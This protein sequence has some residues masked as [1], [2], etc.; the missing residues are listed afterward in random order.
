MFWPN[1]KSPQLCYLAW[2][3]WNLVIQNNIHLQAAHIAGKMNIL[4]DQL[5]RTN[6][7][8]TEW[9]LNR[10]IVDTILSLGSSF[11]RS[12]CLDSQSSEA[13]ILFVDASPRSSS[14]RCSNN[15]MGEDVCLCY[16][17]ICLIP[18][19]LQYMRQF[20]CQIILIAPQWTRR[21]CNADLLQFLIAYPIRL[22]Y[23]PKLVNR[24]KTKIYHPNPQ[25]FNLTAWLL[26]TEV[27]KKK[28]FSQQAR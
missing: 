17:P 2:D 13:N 14:S 9:S 24:P 20:H 5:S 11:D 12:I 10:E 15:F 3:L 4:A 6:I 16:P 18:K 26:S 23:L 25:V 28:G 21:H 7:L 1:I 22:P 19:I 27:S 8:T